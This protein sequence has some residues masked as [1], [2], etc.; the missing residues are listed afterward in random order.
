V[1]VQNRL[2]G[3]I[4]RREVLNSMADNSGSHTTVLEAGSTNIVVAYPDELL[5]DALFRV[6]QHNIGRLMVVSKNKPRQLWG[7][8][9]RAA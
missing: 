8:L 4:T 9:G 6:L 3:V 1:D 2:V 5:V 7:C